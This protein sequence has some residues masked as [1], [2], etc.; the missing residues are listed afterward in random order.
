MRFNGLALLASALV[1]TACS[2]GEKNNAG[3][4]TAAMSG[5]SA[6]A[7]APGASTSAAPS[8]ATGA[9]GT[10]A[11]VP[12]API[13]GTVHDVKMLGDA[14]GYRFDPANITIKQGDGVK[15][16]VVSGQPHDVAFDPSQ[17]PADV[18]AQ[19]SA[20]MPDQMGDL[21]GKM[22]TAPNETYTISFAKI[23]PGTYNY[24]CTPHQALGMKGTITVQ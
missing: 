24:H 17:I 10:T 15:W 18:H 5:A 23:K 20:N 1:L 22:L 2:G 12:A 4:T 11:A 6:G 8:T 14:Q 9:P 7:M 3:G 21:Q 19:L 16:T 13:T